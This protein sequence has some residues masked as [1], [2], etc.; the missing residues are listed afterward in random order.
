MRSHTRT[1]LLLT[2]A[3][4]LTRR[5][6]FVRVLQ[7]TTERRPAV[8]SAVAI[9]DVQTS[10]RYLCISTSRRAPQFDF[11]TAKLASTAAEATIHAPRIGSP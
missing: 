10:A 7:V 5:N 11:H 9:L 3:T 2:Y 4:V 1:Y 6:L 8:K